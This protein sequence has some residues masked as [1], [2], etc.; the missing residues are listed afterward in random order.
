M[1]PWIPFLKS[2]RRRLSDTEFMAIKAFDGKVVTVTGAI[3]A[4]TNT[5][6]YVPASGKTFYFH[7]AKITMTTNPTPAINNSTP[8][9]SSTNEQIVAELKI[10]TT[11]VD[12]ATVG[13]ASTTNLVSVGGGGAGFSKGGMAYF[14]VK[15]RTLEGDGAK[16]IEIENVLDNGSATA[17]LIGWIEDTGN[18][19]QI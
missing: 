9:S 12:S 16:K 7:S 17:T 19:P 1:F 3:N 14:D 2:R 15:G 11:T 13:V 6:E 5:I 4:I 8:T 10:N 18:S